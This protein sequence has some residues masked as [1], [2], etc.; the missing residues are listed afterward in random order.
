VKNTIFMQLSEIICPH[1]CILCGKTGAILCERCKKY[2]L[3]EHKHECLVC[4]GV[5]E[6]DICVRCALPFRKQFWVGKR[7]GALKKLIEIY[8]YQSV[9]ACS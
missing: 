4:G 3:R 6:N 1:Y 7:E 9:R 5:L 8:K 2:I